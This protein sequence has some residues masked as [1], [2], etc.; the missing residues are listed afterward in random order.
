MIR[1][2]INI[3][4]STVFLAGLLSI[5]GCDNQI[6]QGSGFLEGVISIGPICPVETDPPDPGCLPTA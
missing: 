3:I 4:L 2:S 1:R 5:S 6:N